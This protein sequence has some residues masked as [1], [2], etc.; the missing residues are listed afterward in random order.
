MMFTKLLG[1]FMVVVGFILIMMGVISL[2]VYNQEM[3]V[4][5][6]GV[7]MYVGLVIGWEL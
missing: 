3:A 4:L 7:I 6:G 1:R 2:Y 5:G